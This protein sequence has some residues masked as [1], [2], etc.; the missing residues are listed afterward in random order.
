MKDEKRMEEIVGSAFEDMSVADMEMIQG[1][2]DVEA[3]VSPTPA[4]VASSV[5]CAGAVSAI[6]SAVSGAVLSVMKC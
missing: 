3:E 5:E 6:A 2:G 4:I 1:A